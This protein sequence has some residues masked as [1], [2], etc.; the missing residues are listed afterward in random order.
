V[1]SEHRD[2]PRPSAEPFIAGVGEGVAAGYRAVEAVAEG[3]AESLR[4][5]PGAGVGSRTGARQRTG[6]TGTRRGEQ[7]TTLVGEIAGLTADLLGRLGEAAQEIAGHIGEQPGEGPACP[8]IAL[9]GFPG[10]RTGHE[11]LLTN[12]G[13]TAL[14]EVKFEATDLVSPSADP[15]PAGA[16]LFG[17][18]DEERT[19]RIRPGGSREFAVAVEV[20][21]DAAVGTYR[22]VIVG[23]SAAPR[24]RAATEGGPE[25]AWALLE[26]EVAATERRRV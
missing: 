26:L 17:Y 9:R 13:A 21:G 8:T 19:A 25:G 1:A 18:R 5:R 15:I 7:A 3:L 10:E 24:G 14:G 22:G 11:F 12:V 23:H 6:R 16:V 20:P 4:Q 2:P